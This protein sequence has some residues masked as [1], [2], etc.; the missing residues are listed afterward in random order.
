MIAK[1]IEHKLLIMETLTVQADLDSLTKIA[2]YVKQSSEIA[3]LDKK[4]AYKL[5]LAVDE[6]ATNIII[7]GYQEAGKEGNISITEKIE[8]QKL[9][10]TL[11]DTADYFDPQEQIIPE[12]QNIDKPI[13]ER[14][15]GNLGIYL[16]IDGVDQF[17]YERKENINYNTFIVNLTKS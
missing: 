10:I 2:Q 6:I 4:T 14:P 17:L 5:R 11:E 9:I 15:I 3:N 1:P 8:N 16:A 7:H 12:S 13:E